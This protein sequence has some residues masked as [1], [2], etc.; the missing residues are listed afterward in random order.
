MDG[1]TNMIVATALHNPK[2]ARDTLQWSHIVWDAHMAC[3]KLMQSFS[4]AEKETTDRLA[5]RD[6]TIF[7]D[8]DPTSIVDDLLATIEDDSL[9]ELHQATAAP[10]TY[11][12][13]H[14]LDNA[15]QRKSRGLQ[16]GALQAPCL[17]AGTQLL[18]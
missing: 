9:P 7:F 2:A 13:T 17:S 12:R 4:L 16:S 5:P 18:P 11:S 14:P 10:N 3:T 15:R 6:N 8:G 1:S